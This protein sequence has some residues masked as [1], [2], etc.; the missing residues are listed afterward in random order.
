[1]CLLCF[2]AAISSG[3]TRHTETSRCLPD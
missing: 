1:L 2:S 3:D